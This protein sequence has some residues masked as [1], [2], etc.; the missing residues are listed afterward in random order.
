MKLDRLMNAKEDWVLRSDDEEISSSGRED[1]SYGFCP[2]F[3]QR[4]TSY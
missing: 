4:R 1:I 3:H 2:I